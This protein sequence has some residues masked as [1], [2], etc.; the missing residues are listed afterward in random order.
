MNSL[1]V[2][3]KG[4]HEWLSTKR[5]PNSLIIA[6]DPQPFLTKRVRV[7]DPA[8][9]HFNPLTNITPEGA[10]E[11]ADIVYL[12]DP[13]GENTLTVRNGKRALAKL[14]VN[15]TALDTL[16]GNKTD[17]YQA[18]AMAAVDALLFYPLLKKVLC[19]GKPFNFSGT[20]VAKIDRAKLGDKQSLALALMLISQF[21]G[22]VVV[23]D[24][25]FYL[26]PLHV[27]LIRQ[28]R[29]TCGVQYLAELEKDMRQAVL[30]IK[31]KTG[32]GCTY[33]D[34]VVLANYAGLR[35]DP[36]RDDSDYNKFVRERMGAGDATQSVAV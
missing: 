21:K 3:T 33:E 4:L 8:K 29:L 18:E 16:D 13:G 25:G 32:D 11:L 22:H 6:D 2:G 17:P 15:T 34:A 7:F 19:S 31:D 1:H 12:A 5:E 26:R 14:L 27:S 23:L 36:L 30:L 20:V 28:N 24:G 9:H 35:P 10:T